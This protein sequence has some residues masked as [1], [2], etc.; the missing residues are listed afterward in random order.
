VPCNGGRR[1]KKCRTPVWHG[2]SESVQII[3]GWRT[4]ATPFLR[5][6]CVKADGRAVLKIWAN[7][8]Q[9]NREPG[10]GHADR[11]G[12][13]G[14]AREI[15]KRRIHKLEIVGNSLAIHLEQTL[16]HGGIQLP[17]DDVVML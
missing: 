11:E 10:A 8:L 6:K 1:C 5:H 15:C 2:A 17:S 3:P 7:D 14:L 13:G 12:G 4:E 9:T 16:W